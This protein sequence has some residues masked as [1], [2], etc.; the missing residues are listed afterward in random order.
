M[1]PRVRPVAGGAAVVVVNENGAAEAAGFPK[2]KPNPVEAAVD[3][4]GVPV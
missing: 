4:A 2:P 3:A 1:E